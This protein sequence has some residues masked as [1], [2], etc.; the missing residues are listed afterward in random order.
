M[1]DKKSKPEK[2][3]EETIVEQD[4]S[5]GFHMI[6]IHLPTMGANFIVIVL[7]LGAIAL[8]WRTKLCRS[9]VK[10]KRPRI[11][12][13]RY[14]LVPGAHQAGPAPVQQLAPVQQPAP[15]GRWPVTT[16]GNT[17]ANLETALFHIAETVARVGRERRPS[18]PYQDARRF[19]EVGPADADHWGQAS[20]AK[21]QDQASE[22]PRSFEFASD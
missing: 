9:L 21:R 13:G 20:K 10:K 8:L 6:E 15:V 14:G 1:G 18:T 5:S 12:E 16:A 4:N 19:E 17:P 2:P 7:I 11:E 3:A 22:T